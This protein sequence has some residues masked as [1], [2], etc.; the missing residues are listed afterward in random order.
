M[1]VLVDSN[2]ILE[3]ILQREQVEVAN[4]SLSL[5][6]QEKHEV[7]LTVG[8]FYCM[9]YT[10]D[11]YLRKVM[12]LKKPYR[13]HALRAIMIQVLNKYQ[14]VEHDKESLIRSMEDE[15]FSDLEDSCQFQA[16]CKEGCT[17]LVTFNIS[18]YKVNND[19]PVKV[20]TPQELLDLCMKKKE[21]S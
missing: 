19:A 18:D 10:I 3:L 15:A 9:L 8:G 1:K 5:L 17:L 4:K 6:S 12:E 20:V 7:Y 13:A 2:V 21:R 11:N 16:A 14:V